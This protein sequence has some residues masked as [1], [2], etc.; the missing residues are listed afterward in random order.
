LRKTCLEGKKGKQKEGRD[1][2][3]KRGERNSGTLVSAILIDGLTR[4]YVEG[5]NFDEEG[6]TNRAG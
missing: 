5:T 4:V 1:G 2:P 3:G 6:P